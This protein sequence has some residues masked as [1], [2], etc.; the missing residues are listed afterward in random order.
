ME[1]ELENL[2]N[3]CNFLKDLCGI[4]WQVQQVKSRYK[5]NNINNL[6]YKEANF[7]IL[8]A[9]KAVEDLIKD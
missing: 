7:Y 6:T 8:G 3:A 5:V 9:I 4:T 1:K 2:Q